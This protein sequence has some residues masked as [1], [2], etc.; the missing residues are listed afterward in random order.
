MC[1][2]SIV[3]SVVQPIPGAPV[4]RGTDRSLAAPA[5]GLDPGLRRL[6]TTA[7]P[8]SSAQPYRSQGRAVFR[9]TS[10]ESRAPSPSS[11]CRGVRLRRWRR[12]GSRPQ[13]RRW[14]GGSAQGASPRQS[15][16]QRGAWR[17]SVG[18]RYGDERLQGRVRHGGR[19]APTVVDR[20]SRV[21]SDGRGRLD[22]GGA[23]LATA[24]STLVAS[25]RTL[26]AG[27]FDSGCFAR[28][29]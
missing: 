14:R 12:A 4:T 21:G 1:P 2:L 16:R 27:G 8:T 25:P 19:G 9:G 28:E 17:W 22:G 29:R 23:R 26:A 18:Q 24:D 20:L 6:M 15:G 5:S 7:G 10:A 3:A 11:A 13:R